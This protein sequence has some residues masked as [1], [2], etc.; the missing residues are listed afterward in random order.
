[1][2]QFVSSL[3]ESQ[4]DV[5]VSSEESDELP[6]VEGKPYRPVQVKTMGS[7]PE[8]EGESHCR[9]SPLTPENTL[10]EFR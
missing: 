6:A 8:L 2:D 9:D 7:L 5:T 10:S 4:P 3:S 1:M